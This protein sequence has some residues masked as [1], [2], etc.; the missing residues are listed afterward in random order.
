[1]DADSIREVIA[2]LEALG[3]DAKEVF[4]WYLIIDKLPTIILKSLALIIL[5]ATIRGGYLL[6]NTL[7]PNGRLR[8][9]AGV[10]SMWLDRDL[11][12]ACQCLQEHYGDYK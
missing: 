1:M 9:A 8:T 6:I 12:A 5:A 3:G 4:I 10:R 11:D 2:A 7:V